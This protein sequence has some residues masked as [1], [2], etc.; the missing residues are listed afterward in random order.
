[1]DGNPTRRRHAIRRCQAGGRGDNVAILTETD[2]WKPFPLEMS[3][4]TAA[5][6]AENAEIPG[7]AHIEI[8]KER[9]GLL[10]LP[11]WLGTAGTG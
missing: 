3:Y 10:F 4:F 6:M 7:A 1:M 2:P 11:A 9:K 8:K 5:K